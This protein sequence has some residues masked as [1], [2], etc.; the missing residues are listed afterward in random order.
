MFVVKKCYTEVHLH[1]HRYMVDSEAVKLCVCSIV[2]LS[3][4]TAAGYGSCFDVVMVVPK[5]SD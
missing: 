1:T 2:M 4:L 5:F 3:M